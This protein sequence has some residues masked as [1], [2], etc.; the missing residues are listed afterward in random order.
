MRNSN[1]LNDQNV[2]CH[3]E[4]A[5]RPKQSHHLGL[6]L[7]RPHFV[8]ARNDTKSFWSFG[9]LNFD[10][11]SPVPECRRQGDFVLRISDFI[12]AVQELCDG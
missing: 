12:I 7:P 9:Y 1:I 11:V 6:R 2:K 5:K 4:G 3:C 10:I 8:R